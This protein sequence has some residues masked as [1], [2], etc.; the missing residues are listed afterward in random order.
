MVFLLRCP[1]KKAA[2]NMPVPIIV[3]VIT[4]FNDT[5]RNYFYHWLKTALGF[6]RVLISDVRTRTLADYFQT[7]RMSIEAFPSNTAM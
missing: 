7:L 1:N 5:A 3:V 2:P 4:S 6:E